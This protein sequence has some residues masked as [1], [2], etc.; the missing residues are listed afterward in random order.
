M[1]FELEHL[2]C[3]LSYNEDD[4]GFA[5][6]SI[7]NGEDVTVRRLDHGHWQTA[8]TH[9]TPFTLH[10]RP[11]FLSYRAGDGAFSL[12]EIVPVMAHG[13]LTAVKLKPLLKGAWARGWRHFTA[14]V[15]DGHACFLS[16]GRGGTGRYSI[17][18]LEYR[19]RGVTLRKLREG[20]CHPAWTHV[21]TFMLGREPHVLAYGLDG[22][23]FRIQRVESDGRLTRLKDGIWFGGWT[24]LMPYAADGA[25]HLLRYAEGNGRVSFDR[26]SPDGTTVTLGYGTV[27][28]G[29]STLVP[30]EITKGGRRRPCMFCYRRGDGTFEFDRILDRGDGYECLWRGE[31]T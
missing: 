16:Y 30:Y 9:L 29:W 25:P 18:R 21:M 13:V 1:P 26:L 4:G 28:P 23:R 11:C 3:V 15:L 5:F 31:V 6:D 7:A 14:F 10:G 8:W 17:D 22:N 2:P 20:T 19:A 27:A 12:D 24:T